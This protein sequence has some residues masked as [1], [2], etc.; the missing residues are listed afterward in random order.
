LPTEWNASIPRT[1]EAIEK[2]IDQG[3]HPGA[4]VCIWHDGVV[5]A[6]GA[7]GIAA[8]GVPMQP[9]SINLWFSAGKPIAAVALGILKDRGLIDFDAPVGNYWPE[10]ARNGKEG[11]TLRQV[12]THT[13]G[14]RTAEIADRLTTHEEVLAAIAAAPLEP[15]WVPGEKAAYH[16]TSGW[17]VL[18]EFVRRVSGVSYDEF[19]RREIFEPL[20]MVSSTFAI[21]PSRNASLGGSVAVMHLAK[22]G[23]LEPH[24]SF[25]LEKRGAFVRP[26]SGLL[27][28]ASDMTRLYRTLLDMGETDGVR[29][30]NPGTAME[31]TSPHRVGMKDHTFGHVMDWGLGVMLDNKVHGPAAAYG[32]GRYAS[33]RTFGHGGRESS[34]AFADPE[35]RLVVALVFNGIPGEPKHDRRLRMVTGAIYEDLGL[36]SF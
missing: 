22:D 34:T 4:Q 20:G 9:D 8:A 6:N 36:T 13:G 19:T 24:P 5:V 32:Y 29:V 1:V 12:L 7:V 18:G 30:L 3:W 10:F 31:I 21:T 27:S 11:I 26:G 33:P 35:H 16:A 15:D 2:G 17:H 25:S 23:R 28:T 14:F